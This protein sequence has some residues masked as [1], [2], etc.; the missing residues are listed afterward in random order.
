MIDPIIGRVN[1]NPK[2]GVTRNEVDI[3]V[4]SML[5]AGCPLSTVVIT[6]ATYLL[7][8]YPETLSQLT[9]EIRSKFDSEQDILVSSTGEMPYLEVV[10][11][12][13]LRI[14]HPNPSDPKPRAVRPAGQF[15]DNYWLPGGVSRPHQ[16][17]RQIGI[18]S[19]LESSC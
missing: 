16:P 3:N 2:T 5:F 17:S 1:E 19:Y 15:V 11:M 12:E 7:L 4:I 10:I 8:R 14:H 13:T 9:Q 6:A 18:N